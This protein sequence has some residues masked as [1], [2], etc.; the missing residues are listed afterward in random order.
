[1]HVHVLTASLRAA[2]APSDRSSATVLVHPFAM[3]LCSA[4]CLSSL[5]CSGSHTHACQVPVPPTPPLPPKRP[6]NLHCRPPPFLLSLRFFLRAHPLPTLPHTKHAPQHA[7]CNTCRSRA[8][9]SLVASI[10]FD[11]V[12]L[13]SSSHAS[14]RLMAPSYMYEYMHQ[15]ANYM[16]HFPRACAPLSLPPPYRS[17]LQ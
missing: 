13:C 14:S 1:M 3:A 11:A 6:C 9:A 5:S 17:A 12:A 15:F 7:S 16:Y 2:L 10:S 8:P 4:D